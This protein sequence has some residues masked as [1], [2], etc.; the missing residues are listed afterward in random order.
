VLELTV[1]LSESYDDAT[2]RFITEKAT[3]QLEHS[4]L[5]V[6]KWESEFQKPFLVPGEKTAEEVLGYIRCMILTPDFSPEALEA[7]SRDA[8]ALQKI[9]LYWNS[10]Q[11]ASTVPEEKAPANS[12]ERITSEL[13]YYWMASMQIPFHPA[14]TWHLSRLFMLIRIAGVKNAPKKKTNPGSAES[15]AERK[16]ENARRRAAAGSRG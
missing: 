13:I 8:D 5:T 12:R 9:H 3:L 1:V 15:L 16:A 14:E 11:S 7:L 4:L 2:E 10:S 6:S